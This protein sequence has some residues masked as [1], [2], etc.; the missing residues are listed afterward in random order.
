MSKKSTN[1]NSPRPNSDQDSLKIKKL[2]AAKE[3]QPSAIW[4]INAIRPPALYRDWYTMLVAYW[5]SGKDPKF[6]GQL[7]PSYS[8]VCN[9]LQRNKAVPDSIHQIPAIPVPVITADIGG[10]PSLGSTVSDS[11][12]LSG[13][14]ACALKHILKHL[15]KKDYYTSIIRLSSISPK[16][17]SLAKADVHYKRAANMRPGSDKDVD[18]LVRMLDFGSEEGGLEMLAGASDQPQLLLTCGSS[19]ALKLKIT[20]LDK[21]MLCTIQS[22]TSRGFLMQ[23]CDGLHLVGSGTFGAVFILMQGSLDR[24]SDENFPSSHNTGGGCKRRR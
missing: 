20:V 4:W 18:A 14:L 17:L 22:A 23:Y 3:I 2:S 24:N 16:N 11:G 10:S 19:P 7:I 5:M 1:E 13:V 21:D 9:W 12:I 8:T 6:T 15:C